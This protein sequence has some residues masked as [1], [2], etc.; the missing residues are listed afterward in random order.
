MEKRIRVWRIGGQP[1]PLMVYPCGRRCHQPGCDTILSI[2]NP[3]WFCASHEEE[4][5]S[6]RSGWKAS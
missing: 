4:A 5:P 1:S 6:R 2:Y 3:D